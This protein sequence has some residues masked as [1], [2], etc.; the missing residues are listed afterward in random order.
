ML[1][2]EM[3]NQVLMMKVLMAIS[4]RNFRQYEKKYSRYVSIYNFI[5]CSYQ[6][7]TF[8]L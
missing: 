5:G 4:G 6:H 7:S 3:E 8:Y 1:K 2:L